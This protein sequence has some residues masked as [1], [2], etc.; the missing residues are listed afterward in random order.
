MCN[1][2]VKSSWTAR[3][4]LPKWTNNHIVH[5]TPLEKRDNHRRTLQVSI[6]CTVWWRWLRQAVDARAAQCIFERHHSAAQKAGSNRPQHCPVCSTMDFYCTHSFLVLEWRL[7]MFLALSGYWLHWRW[8]K[9]LL[10]YH[11]VGYSWHCYTSKSVIMISILWYMHLSTLSHVQF[12]CNAKRAVNF[13][14][15]ASSLKEKNA[16]WKQ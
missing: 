9:R 15:S 7:I 4:Q 12:S 2:H 5:E 14:P 11:M 3:L 16:H 8:L 13:L 10:T 1:V 6:E